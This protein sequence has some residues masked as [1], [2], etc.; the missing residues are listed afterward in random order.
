MLETYYRPTSFMRLSLTSCQPFFEEL[1]LLLQPL[2]LL[3]FNLDLL[4][5]HHHL[6]PS[7][8]SLTPASHT[9]EIYSPPNEDFSF[10]L[11][12]KGLFQGSSHHFGSVLAH[13]HGSLGLDTNPNSGLTSHILDLSAYRNPISLSSGIT[14]DEASSPLSWFK[15][16]EISVPL[17]A[18]S[19]SQQAGQALHQGWGAV[20]RF[21]ER[22]GQNFSLATTTEDDESPNL[23]VD[24]K[25]GF[26]LN[27]K[28]ADENRQQP[29]DDLSLK[30]SGAA[31]PWGLG[32][33]FGASKSPNNPPASR[34]DVVFLNICLV[35]FRFV[36]FIYVMYLYIFFYTVDAHLS[37]CPQAYLS[38][39]A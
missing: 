14:K 10:H 6:D 30:D 4:F 39:P 16:N 27:P 7:S 1:L 17:N 33:L 25:T 8:P 12:P 19:L 31:V 18:G 37:G 2:S 34:F 13:D 26:S 22:L 20:M 32:R 15:G 38:F 29:I 36:K 11:S 3:T 28:S 9:S 23:P 5:Q 21:G 24:F 35:Y